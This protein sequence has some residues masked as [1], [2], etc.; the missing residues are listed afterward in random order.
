M[1]SSN[2]ESQDIDERLDNLNKLI[3]EQRERC[4]LTSAYR[5]SMDLM[6]LA[7]REQRLIPLLLGQF[8]LVNLAQDLFQH[9][10]ARDVSIE[11][12]A[13]LESPERARQIQADYPEQEY[14]ETC[15]WMT[16]CAYDNLAEH[17]GE[18]QG[19]NS[20]GMH[21]CIA[22]GIEVCRR[23]GKL[24]CIACFREYASD[25]YLAAD[26]IDMAL[27]HLSVVAGL[28]ENDA[29]ATRR[30]VATKDKAK[31]LALL[32]ELS[33]AKDTCLRALDLVP[34][35]HSPL[36][37]RLETLTLLESILWLLGEQDAF[38]TYATE[39]PGNRSIT[40][41]ED[42]GQDCRWDYRDALAACCRGEFAQAIEL[43]TKWDT[44]LSQDKLANPWFEA[45][46]RLIAAHRLAGRSD[47]I[48]NLA[49]PLV[50]R[51]E[52]AR[53]WL[54]L[55]RLRRLVDPTEPS[56]PTAM[57]STPRTGTFAATGVTVPEGI[58]SESTV[59]ASMESSAPE[60]EPAQSPMRPVFDQI[61]E[62]L[63]SSDE[64]DNKLDVLR[65][66]L[67]LVPDRFTDPRDAA[68]FLHLLPFL[69]S[70][71]A[72]FEAIWTWGQKVA[73]PF[74]QTAFV[75]SLLAS[76]GEV[77]RNWPESNMDKRIDVQHLDTLFRQALVVDPDN[78]FSHAQ[79][80]GFYLGQG[81]LGEAE[82][83]LA[84]G[85]RL[86]RHNG[87]LA[88]RLADIYQRT[89]RPRD[90]LAVLDLCLR[91]GCQD[92]P[93]AWEAAMLAHHL[94]QFESLLTYLDC[95][96]SL[97]PDE[98]W[99]GHYRAIGL[100]ERG[101]PEQALE[102]LALEEQ[103]SPDRPFAI[104]I[105]RACVASALG[106]S[107]DYRRHVEKILA[108]KWATVDYF[109]W[110]GF[111][112]LTARL[113]KASTCLPAGDEQTTRLAQRLILTGLAPD[114]LFES[115]RLEGDIT[116]SVRLYRCTLVQP[117][118]ERWADS[119]GCLHGQAEWPAYHCLWGVLAQDEEEA[120]RLALAEQAA[121]Y[122]LEA[123]VVEVEDSGQG[124][125]DK[126]GPVWQGI[127]C[128]ADEAGD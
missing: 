38:V 23:T 58:P 115:R 92:A 15:A 4:Q 36:A 27:H 1:S 103:R 67:A 126:P 13:L 84:R 104:D 11:M 90:A 49:Q 34:T 93:V 65:Q 112:G 39:Q 75:L 56:T 18:I 50:Q 88:L 97:Q 96:E 3:K 101:Q 48:A 118:D 47:K 77:L 7:R 51:A 98:P 55:R 127:R 117:L 8:E 24:G 53:D 81:N 52:K 83:C 42:V 57:L 32:G 21:Q 85:F 80:G 71:E 6:R 5:L 41:G 60:P 102:A 10:R 82:R 63:Q 100:L 43:L 64:D 12:I 62:Q 72:P 35:Y 44:K 2:P 74:P 30:W 122:D 31:T 59:G 128:Y 111:V 119:P 28:S 113:W 17:T 114:A 66:V 29:G 16:A 22:D 86:Q 76:L 19:F 70:D 40:P 108:V 125:T 107:E 105:L 20:D 37:A 120:A 14:A 124:Y 69:L 79:A 25:V 94:E 121:C 110:N 99:V 116:A 54:T 68:S 26:D 78:A 46:L 33:A 61:V 109:T 91:E 87:S 73:A 9:H 106:R 95:F 45:R 123:E 89:D